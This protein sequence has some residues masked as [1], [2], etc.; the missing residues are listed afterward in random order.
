MPN[1]G[2][3]GTQIY[4]VELKA[5]ENDKRNTWFTAPWLYAEFVV[6]FHALS[7]MLKEL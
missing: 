4:N 1:D 3:P 5:L 6:S 7:L 2:E